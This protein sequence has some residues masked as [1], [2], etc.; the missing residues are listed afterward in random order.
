LAINRDVAEL[1]QISKLA[2]LGQV[3]Q[4]QQ[5]RYPCTSF[6]DLLPEIN[7]RDGTRMLD[8]NDIEQLLELSVTQFVRII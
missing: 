1:L 4:T 6:M 5:E 3:S 2:Y 7:L 8:S